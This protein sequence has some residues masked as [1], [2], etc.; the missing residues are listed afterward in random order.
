MID[1][2]IKQRCHFHFLNSFCP[3]E[4][5]RK[6]EKQKQNAGRSKVSEAFL[7]Q[8]HFFTRKVMRF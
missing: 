1:S 8:R 3:N 6:K 4:N 5:I 2:R 7:R